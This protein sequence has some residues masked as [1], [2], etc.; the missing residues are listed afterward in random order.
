VMHRRGAL[1]RDRSFVEPISAN[2]LTPSYLI[3]QQSSL[4]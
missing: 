1:H 3:S 2:S 4:S